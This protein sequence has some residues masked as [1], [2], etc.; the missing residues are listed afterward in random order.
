MTVFSWCSQHSHC[1]YEEFREHCVQFYLDVI[2]GSILLC[3]L[4]LL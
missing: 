3:V 2:Y 4:T 1:S